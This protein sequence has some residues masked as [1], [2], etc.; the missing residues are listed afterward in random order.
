MSVYIVICI[1]MV[2]KILCIHLYI[3]ICMYLKL[4]ICLYIHIGGN[5]II[6]SSR[7]DKDNNY[8]DAIDDAIAV[9][10]LDP[11]DIHDLGY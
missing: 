5:R 9:G 7:H 11:K 4:F 3:C 10:E 1:Y 6:D 8:T 2:C